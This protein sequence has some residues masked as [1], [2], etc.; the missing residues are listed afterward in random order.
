MFAMIWDCCCWWLWE[1]LRAPWSDEIPFRGAVITWLEL[2]LRLRVAFE[3]CWEWWRVKGE[4]SWFVGTFSGA[5]LIKRILKAREVW[6]K[7]STKSYAKRYLFRALHLEHKLRYCLHWIYM[8]TMPPV[9]PTVTTTS[10]V[11]KGQPSLSLRTSSADRSINTHKLQITQS[12]A[13][14]WNS[15]AQKSRRRSTPDMSRLRHY[16]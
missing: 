16:K 1:W 3:D 12:A 13:A 14:R 7:V 10:F 11:Q 4:L 15:T 5:L 6:K 2:L 9:R 8:K